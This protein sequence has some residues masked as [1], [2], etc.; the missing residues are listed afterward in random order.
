MTLSQAID[1]K[2]GGGMFRHEQ[3]SKTNIGIHLYSDYGFTVSMMKRK[4]VLQ[5]EWYVE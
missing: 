3:V 1:L 5:R 4:T 2:G